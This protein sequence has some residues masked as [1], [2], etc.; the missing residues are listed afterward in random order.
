MKSIRKMDY[1]R[2]AELHH[3]ERADA[4]AFGPGYRAKVLGHGARGARVCAS[5]ASPRA[6]EAASAE[7]LGTSL[8]CP[9]TLALLVD[10][11]V[12]STGQTYERKA[13]ELVNYARDACAR[14]RD[15]PMRV[16]V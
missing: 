3:T 16:L 4:Y 10:P 15:D 2:M 12:A 14:T 1:R 6:A 11:V 5:V 13:L 9:I 7:A 8:S